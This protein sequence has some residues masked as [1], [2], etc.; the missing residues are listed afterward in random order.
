LIEN[1]TIK[2]IDLY[3]S[4][5]LSNFLSFLTSFAVYTIVAYIVGIHYNFSI[6]YLIII[7]INI[8]LLSI[9]G[10]MI[11]AVLYIFVKDIDHLWDVIR[12]FLFWTSG[13]FMRGEQLLE[14]YPIVMFLNPLIS[15]LVN[16]RKVVFQIEPINFGLL[17]F[18]LAYGLIIFL[19]GNFIFN[20]YSQYALERY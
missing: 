5:A 14:D 15:V 8:T 18:S 16:V 19:F 17:G 7:I 12:L 20:K 13:V 10:G 1:I 11:L 4:N 3:L 2:K 6:L 9:G